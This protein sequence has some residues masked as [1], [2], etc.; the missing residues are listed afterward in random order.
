MVPCS[1]CEQERRHLPHPMTPQVPVTCH[2]R[3]APSHIG[4]CEQ[5]AQQQQLWGRNNLYLFG[6]RTLKDYRKIVAALETSVT[7][8]LEYLQLGSALSLYMLVGNDC[9][10]SA[11]EILCFLSVPPLVLYTHTHKHAHTYA[12]ILQSLKCLL[13]RSS[14]LRI[15]W[16]RT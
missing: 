11:W 2:R 12:V 7:W 14:M 13:G 16:K 6:P 8:E 5:R 15:Q 10:M 4:R 3:T 9:D 1:L